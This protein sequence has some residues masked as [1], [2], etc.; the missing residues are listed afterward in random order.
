MFFD[1]INDEIVKQ[2]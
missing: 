1:D 2:N